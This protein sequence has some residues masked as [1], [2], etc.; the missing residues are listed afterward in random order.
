MLADPSLLEVELSE[1]SPIAK[2][3]RA[4]PGAGRCVA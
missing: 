3:K 2:G 4:V 1:P